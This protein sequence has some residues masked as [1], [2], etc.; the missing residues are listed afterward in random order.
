M[1]KVVVAGMVGNGL[2]W[3]DFALYGCLAAMLST[4]FFPDSDPSVALI[5]TYGIFAAGF[6]MR[7]VGAL[8]F[9]FL[10]DKYGRKMALAASILLMAIPTGLIG[11]LPTYAQIGL[12]A[13]ISLAIL[14][15]L[16]GVALGGEFSGSITYVVEHSPKKHR[17]LAGST[18]IISLMLGVL[19]GSLVATVTAK[20]MGEAAFADWGWRIPFILGFFIGLIGLYIRSHLHESP[21]FVEAQETKNI[22]ERPVRELFT[23]HW[24]GI[25]ASTGF[26]M[27]VTIPFYLLT[28]FMNGYMEKFLGYSAGDAFLINTI[29]ML[30]TTLVLPFAAMAADRRGV[31]PVLMIAL[32][33]ML[34]AAVPIYMLLDSG[35]FMLALLGQILFGVVLGIYIAPIPT[36]LVDI[37]PTRIRFTGM[38]VACNLC[39]ATFGGTT[40][41]FT[42]WMI[43]TTGNHLMPAFYIIF[44]VLVSM[45]TMYLYK[46]ESRQVAV[47]SA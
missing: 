35:N 43:N 9:G 32:V 38:A 4:Q 18:S 7:P 26:Y 14:R 6:V 34:F 16:Q 1:K 31:R 45:L 27:A 11:I 15:L 39:A 29:S 42:A 25:L 5:K 47:A 19:L 41:M 36:V 30:T 8:F 28:V 20:V 40:P 46:K 33:A 21:E 17:V 37:F 22:S 3:Y 44:S 10:G 23:Q 12:L 24:K 13:P 2:E